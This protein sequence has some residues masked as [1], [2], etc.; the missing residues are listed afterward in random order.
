MDDGFNNALG[1][2]DVRRMQ[3][4]L[5]SIVTIPGCH[6]DCNGFRANRPAKVIAATANNRRLGSIQLLYKIDKPIMM[7]R[8]ETLTS[9]S[10]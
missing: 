4:L 3:K 2:L 8:C 6:P 1:K 5:E 7:S 9:T 10:S